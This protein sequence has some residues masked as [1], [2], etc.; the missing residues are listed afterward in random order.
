MMPRGR[1][2]YLVLDPRNVL[3]GKVYTAQ[4]RHIAGI[5]PHHPQRRGATL[6]QWRIV[7]GIGQ[8]RSARQ[9]SCANSLLGHCVLATGPVSE[10]ERSCRHEPQPA[11]AHGC[12]QWPDDRAE[13]DRH[14]DVLPA[15]AQQ[16]CMERP[17][18]ELRR[19]S[20][21]PPPPQPA[22]PWQQHGEDPHAPHVARGETA[23]PTPG[24]SAHPDIA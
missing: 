17:I 2:A 24:V 7:D 20:S 19:Q 14:D 23:A 21:H 16:C 3:A 10:A 6:E 12:E 13:T 9:Q 1:T 18:H 4:R 22:R 8:H 11:E 15:S 5:R